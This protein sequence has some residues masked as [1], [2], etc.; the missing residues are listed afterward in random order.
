MTDFY[1]QS[2][3]E[4]ELNQ[5][6]YLNKA[7]RIVVEQINANRLGL[8]RIEMGDVY[9]VS[10]IYTLGN[11]KALLGTTFPDLMY[12]EVTYDV[13]KKTT[14]FDAYKKLLNVEIAD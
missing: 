8:G 9:V 1:E 3:L 11:F 10:F 14:Y 4:S 13:V 5:D 2:L 12:Y 7:K 6:R